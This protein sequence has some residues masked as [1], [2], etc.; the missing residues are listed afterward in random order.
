MSNNTLLCS[1]REFDEHSK[2]ASQL[3]IFYTIKSCN[4]SNPEDIKIGAMFYEVLSL[5]VCGHRGE[6]SYAL[7]F[8][9]GLNDPDI[10]K[11]VTAVGK[12]VQQVSQAVKQAPSAVKKQTGCCI[13]L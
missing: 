12:E 1:L 8:N 3:Y 4:S 6:F 2:T 7:C 5:L 13:L 11:E 10:I 9:L